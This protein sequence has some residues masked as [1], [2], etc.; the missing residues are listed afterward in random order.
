[1]TLPI[2]EALRL[3]RTR[4]GLTQIAAAGSWKAEEC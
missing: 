2:A 4:K 1:M 3:L